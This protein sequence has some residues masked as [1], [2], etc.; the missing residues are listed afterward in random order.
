[1]LDYRDMKMIKSS[2][3]FSTLTGAKTHYKEIEYDYQWRKFMPKLLEER[4]TITN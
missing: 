2:F 3:C 1:M 4:K